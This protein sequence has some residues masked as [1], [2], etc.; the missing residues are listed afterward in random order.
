M[1]V[2]NVDL[3]APCDHVEQAQIRRVK[4]P[5][6][7]CEDCLKIGGQWV[8]LRACLTCGHVSCCDSSPNRHATKHFQTTRHPIVTS[9]EVGEDWTW[10]YIDEQFLST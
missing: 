3:S 10:C 1:S 5:A 9:V 4:R 7:G 6:R 2:S 8:H